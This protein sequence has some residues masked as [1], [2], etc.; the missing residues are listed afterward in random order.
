MSLRKRSSSCI[1]LQPRDDKEELDLTFLFRVFGLGL[2][3]RSR[4]SVACVHWELCFGL[5]ESPVPPFCLFHSSPVLSFL[6]A[7]LRIIAC[8]SIG[9]SEP[10]RPCSPNKVRLQ[11]PFLSSMETI[12]PSAPLLQNQ[13]DASNFDELSMDQSLLF[14]DSL[15]DLKNLR[16]QLYSAAEYFELSYATDDHKQFVVNTLREYAI[17]AVV[18]TVDHLGSVS[19]KVTGLLEAK[20]DEVSGAESR[21]SCIE[22]DLSLPRTRGPRRALATVAEGKSMP[23]SGRHAIPKYEKNLNAAKDNTET[24]K[25]QPVHPTVVDKAPS[26][27]KTRT[28]SPAPSLRARSVSPRRIPSS[29]PS[30]LPGKLFGAEK[31]ATSP[32]RMP[33]PLAR[34]GSLAV[35]PTALRS[36]SSIGRQY[37]SATQKSAS[38]CLHAERNDEKDG[39]QNPSKGKKFLKSLL[40]RRKSKKDEMVYSYL[41]EY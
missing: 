24:H 25:F 15:K 20:V 41:D 8:P 17:K 5:Q 40:S 36:T 16:S 39:E 35:R 9:Q 28:M 10:R 7:P 14:S 6:W 18:N 31:R 38:M 27:R 19:F 23:E 33:N 37:S 30:Q 29:S 4:R 32:I 1:G 13:L 21:V 3:S 34:S 11:L 26:F 12:S 22:Q 2:P